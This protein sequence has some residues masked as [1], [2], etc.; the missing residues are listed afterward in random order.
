MQVDGTT[1]DSSTI[2][3]Y[4]V[5]GL[6]Y[7]LIG[8]NIHPTI[9][10]SIVYQLTGSR[11]MGTQGSFSLWG[12]KARLFGQIPK[13]CLASAAQLFSLLSGFH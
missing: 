6:K 4:V 8:H 3:L 7:T 1:P 10:L 11:I 9:D 5:T 13:G 2:T 12:A